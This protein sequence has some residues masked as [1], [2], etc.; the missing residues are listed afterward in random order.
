MRKEV[1]II[2]F[3]VNTLILLFGIILILFNYESIGGSLTATGM[4]AYIVFWALLIKDSYTKKDKKILELIKRFGIVDINDKRLLYEKYEE[5]RKKTKKSFDIL[6][7]GLHTFVEDNRNELN[8]WSR[9][10]T[11]R[12]LVLNP[13]N[14]NCK[15]RD[16]EEGDKFGK[17]KSEILDTTETILKLQNSKIV[18][19]WYD[20]I[21]FTNILRMDSIMWVGPYFIQERSRNAYI[22]TLKESGILFEKYLTHFERIWKDRKLSKVPTLDEV[23]EI[24]SNNN[25]VK[26]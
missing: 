23:Y 12:I 1:M 14:P 21:P 10:F 11:I 4:S 8:Y 22:L 15:M 19:K 7:F 3:L 9:L 26:E 24:K 5:A 18:I 6:G 20:A 17:I 16:Y 25:M 13:K 2:Y